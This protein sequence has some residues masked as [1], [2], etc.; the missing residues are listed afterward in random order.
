MYRYRCYGAGTSKIRVLG[1][2]REVGCDRDTYDP[3]LFT[4]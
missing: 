1:G 4:M 3:I 2:R